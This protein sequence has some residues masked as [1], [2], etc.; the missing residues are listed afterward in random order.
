M[1]NEREDLYGKNLKHNFK[2]GFSF[3][4]SDESSG[5]SFVTKGVLGQSTTCSIASTSS[6]GCLSD[7]SSS[8]PSPQ[9]FQTPPPEYSRRHRPY[10]SVTSARQ[11]RL[12]LY[13]LQ[14][15]QISMNMQP[16]RHSMHT[17]TCIRI[18]I[19]RPWCHYIAKLYA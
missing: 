7:R 14:K 8:I 4:V 3:P 19:L 2:F 9:H 17:L 6:L 16:G 15:Q 5:D 1:R 12:V 13:H 18:I 10:P 11:S